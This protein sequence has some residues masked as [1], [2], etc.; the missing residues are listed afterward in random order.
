MVGDINLF[1]HDYYDDNEA[2]LDVNKECH[3]LIELDYDP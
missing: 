1:M 2:E 3:R